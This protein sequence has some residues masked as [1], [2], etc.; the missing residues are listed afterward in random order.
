VSNQPRVLVLGAG[1]MLG[2]KMLQAATA[3]FPETWAT[4][5]GRVADY[6]VD[7]IAAFRSER[8]IEGCDA[9]DL[10][11]VDALLQRIRPDVVV[12]C[13]GVIKQRAAAHDA[14]PSITINALLPHRLA[15]TLSAWN[16]RLVH[17][18]TDC[19]FDGR[20]GGYTETDLTSAE[21]LYGRTKALGEVVT[22]NAITL[23][24]SIIGR[25]LREHHSLL[26]WTLSQNHRTIKGFRQAWWSGVTT[27]HLADLIVRLIT[28]H[29]GLSGLYQVSSGRISKYD[30]LHLIRASFRLD[31]EILPDDSYV[32]DRSMDGTALAAA[33]GYQCPPLATLIDEMAADPTHHPQV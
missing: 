32:L 22:P 9:M 27:N 31:I 2:H 19:V 28:S 25:E 16:G 6:P 24:T 14:L 12:N 7:G 11:G 18:S 33:I 30:L 4:L 13:V 10:A 15:A 23:R 17:L 21:D 5:R 3:A 1:G 29:S 26:D 20:T 8:M